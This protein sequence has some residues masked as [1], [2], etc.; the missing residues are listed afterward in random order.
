M[1]QLSSMLM[2][3][4]VGI[5]HTLKVFLG[6]MDFNVHLCMTCENLLTSQHF[7]ASCFH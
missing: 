2:H 4:H 1:D 5:S 3:L 6:H 7:I